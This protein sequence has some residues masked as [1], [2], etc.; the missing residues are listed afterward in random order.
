M[1]AID[2][3]FNH[4]TGIFSV[5]KKDFFSI[6]IMIR[7]IS[8]STFL[9]AFGRGLGGD[10]FF[11]IYVNSIVE[12]VFRVSLIAALFSLVKMLLSVSIGELEDH[13]DTR[14]I[15]F[16]SKVAYIITSILFFLAGIYH[17]I[18]VL[19]IAVVINGIGSAALFT[20][21]EGVIRKYAKRTNKSSSFGLYFSSFNLA[22]VLGALLAAFSVQYVAMPYLYLFIGLFAAG[23]FLTDSKLPEMSNKKQIKQYLGKES[24]L[25]NFFREVFSFSAIKRGFA[26]LK[27]YNKK[28]YRALSDE[29]LF[30]ILNY[31]GFIFIPIIAVANDLS[32]SQI[33]IVFAV[34]KMPYVIN[35]FTGEFIDKYNKKKFILIVL[36]FLSFLYALLGFKDGFASIITISLGISFGLSLLRPAIS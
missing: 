23:S 3:E 10:T 25:H 27:K 29:V 2:K 18:P 36:L 24:F 8:L 1:Q 4:H 20:T 30:N 6:P 26:V 7:V 19:I 31:I 32:L 34:M 5:I 35:F 22:L 13:G 17:S 9:F 33:A 21:Y 16:L 11:S 28:M 15:I 12:K 14:S